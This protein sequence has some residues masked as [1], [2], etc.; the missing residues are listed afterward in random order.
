MLDHDCE[1]LIPRMVELKQEENFSLQ[2]K[3]TRYSNSPPNPKRLSRRIKHTV[4]SK[5]NSKQSEKAVMCDNKPINSLLL[6]NLL[7]EKDHGETLSYINFYEKNQKLVEQLEKNNFLTQLEYMKLQAQKINIYKYKFLLFLRDSFLKDWL[8]SPYNACQ[9]Q[10]EDHVKFISEL[11]KT[12]LNLMNSN[13]H[14]LGNIYNI[15]I[16]KD[17][18]DPI[19]VELIIDQCLAGL[20][21]THLPKEFQKILS[22]SFAVGVDGYNQLIQKI[23]EMKTLLHKISIEQIPYCIKVNELLIIFEKTASSEEYNIFKNYVM[24]IN[25]LKSNYEGDIF[26]RDAN[27]E[28][29][30][31]KLSHAGEDKNNIFRDINLQ[32]ANL[33]SELSDQP[34]KTTQ[35]AVMIEKENVGVS[36]FSGASNFFHTK[37]EIPK[38]QQT[39]KLAQYVEDKDKSIGSVAKVN[40]K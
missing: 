15:K 27:I 4:S 6:E 31:K 28:L 1:V 19:G 29:Y 10:L 35:A 3:K 20:Y 22:S 7:E 25:Q 8:V 38:I 13:I 37:P 21:F 24:I 11:R 2:R 39:E 26:I 34:H 33:I 16:K 32:I 30:I 9:I 17:E 5:I 12:I 36:N 40:W 18:P 14:A 23:K